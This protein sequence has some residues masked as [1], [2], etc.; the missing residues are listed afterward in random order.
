MP[1]ILNGTTGITTPGITNTGPFTFQGVVELPAGA[2]GAPSLTTTGDTNTGIYFPAADTIGFVEGG[3]EALRINSSAQIAVNTA[4]TAG[5]PVI[6]KTDDL[7]TGIFFPAADTIAFSEGGVE[8]MR[9]DSSGVLLLGNTSNYGV[10]SFEANSLQAK[11]PIVLAANNTGSASNRNWI[12]QANA[13]AAGAFSLAYSST[14]TGWPNAAYAMVVDSSGNLGLGVTP[15]AWDTLLKAITVTNTAVFSG[16]TNS[17]GMRLGSNWYFNGGFRYQTSAAATRYDQASGGHA[18]FNAASGTAGNAISFTQAMTL[19]ASGNLS[20]GFTGGASRLEV[21]GPMYVPAA[22]FKQVGSF[23]G[24]DSQAA[25]NGGGIVLGGVF[26]GTSVTAFAQ[27]AGIKE[28][29]TDSNFAGVLAFYSRPNGDTLQERARFN[30][31]GAFVFAGGTTTANGIGITF[32]AT[33]VASSNANT[34]D[35]YEEGSFTF[36]L[37]AGS[38]SGASGTGFY[39]KIGRVVNVNLETPYATAWPSGGIYEVRGLPFSASGAPSFQGTMYSPGLG[40]TYR[41]VVPLIQTGFYP[42]AMRFVDNSLGNGGSWIGS[43]FGS[44]TFTPST[45]FISITYTT[46]T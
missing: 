16:Q 20:L 13:A 29:S 24:T 18:W 22:N 40:T 19:D 46:A 32:P 15:A 17:E 37:F 1:I 39:T 12:F 45:T 4:G 33:Q 31:T 21:R 8:S 28:N 7:N 34:L 23:L 14:N 26:T 2:V 38:T 35:D 44:S 10:G 25:G 11:G 36:T 42:T 5:A 6:T 27:V 41:V 3:V 30:S 9:I 43:E